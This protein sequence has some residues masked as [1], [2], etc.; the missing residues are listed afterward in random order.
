M[1][2]EEVSQNEYSEENLRSDAKWLRE[3]AAH[4][5]AKGND[6]YARNLRLRA[7]VKESILKDKRVQA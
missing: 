6:K 4:E 1:G 7:Y 5:Q 2:L 3:Q